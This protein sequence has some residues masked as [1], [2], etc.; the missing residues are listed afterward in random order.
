LKPGC[1]QQGLTEGFNNTKSDL[2]LPS[3][4]FGLVFFWMVPAPGGM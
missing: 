2:L 3:N 1:W 4:Y